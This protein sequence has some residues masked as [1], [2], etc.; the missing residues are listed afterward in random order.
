[1][2]NARFETGAVRHPVDEALLYALG[3]RP[4]SERRQKVHHAFCYKTPPLDYVIE[5]KSTYVAAPNE[6]GRS[7]SVSWC[8]SILIHTMARCTRCPVSHSNFTTAYY[9]AF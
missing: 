7:H 6:I 4:R 1:M 3:D 9:P 5:V 2:L 8:G